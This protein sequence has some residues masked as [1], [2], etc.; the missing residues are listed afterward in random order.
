M[1]KRLI[2]AKIIIEQEKNTKAIFSKSIRI[3][4]GKYCYVRQRNIL[5]LEQS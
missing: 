2:V 5:R 4:S 1:V 3:M